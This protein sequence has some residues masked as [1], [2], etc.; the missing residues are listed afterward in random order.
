MKRKSGSVDEWLGDAPQGLARIL[1]GVRRLQ[2]LDRQLGSA[3]EP[4]IAAQV[5]AAGLE[6]GRLSLVTPSAAI[7]A[8]LRIE[9]PDLVRAMLSLGARDVR[10][11]R[12]RVAPLPNTAESAPVRRD[13]PDAALQ[14]L[15]R[16]ARDTG[17]EE[18]NDKLGQAGPDR[19]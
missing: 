4:A 13:L 14:A 9:A 11:I 15:R 7:A 10:E 1:A 16:F 3:L 5:R 2:D 17:D 6:N 8:R 18:L 12:V 19:D